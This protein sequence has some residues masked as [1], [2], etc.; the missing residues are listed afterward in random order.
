MRIINRGV[1]EESCVLVRDSTSNYW[2]KSK[3]SLGTGWL[4]SESPGAQMIHG[5]RL[6]RIAGSPRSFKCTAYVLTC[7]EG[8]SW[9]L[10]AS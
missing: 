7:Y 6:L 3:Y 9:A 4:L 5:P 10:G 8:D 1:I 2:N